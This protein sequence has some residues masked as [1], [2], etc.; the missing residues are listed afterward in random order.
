VTRRF[1]PI[2]AAALAC[3]LFGGCGSQK[4][5]LLPAPPAEIPKAAAPP[6]PARAVPGPLPAGPD[7]G[8]MYRDA[9]AHTREWVARGEMRKAIPSWEA[10][11]GSPFAADAV[12]NQGVLLQLS[13]D[14]DAAEARY[15]RAAAPPLLSEPA[16]ANLLGIALLRGNRGALRELVDDAVK[17]VLLLPGKRLPEFTSNLAAALSD[18]GRTEEAAALFRSLEKSASVPPALPWNRAVLAYRTGDLASARSLSSAL[19]PSVA[20]LWPVAA[21]RMAWERETANVPAFDAKNPAGSRYLSLSRNLAAYD[22]WRK[23]DPVAAARILS[24]EAQGKDPPGEYLTNLG[25][26]FAEAG[27]WKEAQAFLER[28]TVESPTLAEG[29]LN[30]GLYRELYLGDRQGAVSAY[31]MY[32]TLKGRRADEVSKWAEW[33]KK[34][35]PSR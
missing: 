18:L 2:L 1:S 4:G 19:P 15:R 14:L 21:S 29:W 10:L 13:G 11:E 5:M 6:A 32:G 20:G 24:P 17:P 22:A 30:L 25:L 7:Y 23:G 27:R 26:L 16:A 3:A 33:L 34:S 35:S 28:A 12:F 31:E 9:L 8:R